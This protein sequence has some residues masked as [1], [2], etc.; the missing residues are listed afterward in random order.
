M[1]LALA[2]FAL[3]MLLGGVSIS[4]KEKILPFECGFEV[5]YQNRIPFSV[6]F[7]LV[8]II[9]VVF[10]L[11]IVVVFATVFKYN[12]MTSVSIIVIFFVFLTGTLFLE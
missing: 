10:D 9:F 6:Q 12:N 11:E 4:E 5:N 7:F 2:I 1:A 8:G 3:A